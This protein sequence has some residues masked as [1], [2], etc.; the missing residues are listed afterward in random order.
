MDGEEE[1]R[2]GEGGCGGGSAE[3]GKR[4]LEGERECLI[5]AGLQ[6]VDIFGSVK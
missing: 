2:E 5:L 3:S 1:K 6:S 4:K